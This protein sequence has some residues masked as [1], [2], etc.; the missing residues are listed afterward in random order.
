ML[1]EWPEAVLG[2]DP[3]AVLLHVLQ[4]I[5]TYRFGFVYGNYTHAASR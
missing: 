5:E 3:V 4:R 2:V 1:R